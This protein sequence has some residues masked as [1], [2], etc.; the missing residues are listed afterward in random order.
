MHLILSGGYIL[1]LDAPTPVYTNIMCV[2]FE[3]YLARST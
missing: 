1:D 2:Y 3:W